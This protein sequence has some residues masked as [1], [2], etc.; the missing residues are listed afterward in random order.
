MEGERGFPR[1]MRLHLNREFQRV[2][3]TGKRRHGEGF[4]LIFAPNGLDFRRLGL[5]VRRKVGTAVRRNRVKRL[6]RECFRLHRERFPEACDIVVTVRPDFTCDSL[7]AVTDAVFAALAP[8]PRS[9]P[10]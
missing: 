8:R 4:S 10:A 2:Y 9:K 5:S 6:F 7:S 1:R 3:E